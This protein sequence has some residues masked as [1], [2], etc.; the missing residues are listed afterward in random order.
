MDKR[1]RIVRRVAKELKD[2]DY[3]NLGI[4]LPTL[5]A[6]FVPPGVDITLHSE[7]GLLG[8]GPYPFDAEVDPDL[9]NAGKETVTETPGSS[10]FSSADSFAMVRGGHI[11]LTVLGALQIDQHGNLANWMIPGKMVKG[12]GGAMDLVAGAKKVIVAM[13]HT[14]REGGAKIL[15]Q[16]SLPLTGVNVVD[17]IVTELAVIDVTDRGLVLREI[18]DGVDLEDVTK[19]TEAELTIAAPLGRF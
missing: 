3:V 13:E 4:G 15:R 16:C 12:M 7:N 14:T 11:D 10:Y 9:I 17:M 18:A 1:E 8:V 2:G 5:V 19:A 6:N